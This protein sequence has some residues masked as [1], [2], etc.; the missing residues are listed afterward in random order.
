M[1]VFFIFLFFLYRLGSKIPNVKR[2]VD[3]PVGS[4]H[5]HDALFVLDHP[6]SFVLT[7]GAVASIVLVDQNVFGEESD[8]HQMHMVGFK[9]GVLEENFI[10]GIP[11]RVVEPDLD[12]FQAFGNASIAVPG[13]G[14]ADGCPDQSHSGCFQ[15]VEKLYTSQ[16]IREGGAYEPSLEKWVDVVG[17]QGFGSSGTAIQLLADHPGI[18]HHVGEIPFGSG[19]N[20]VEEVV[21]TTL[22]VEGFPDFGSDEVT[23]PVQSTNDPS[24]VGVSLNNVESLIYPRSG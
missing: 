9:P 24:L 6:I 14:G 17:H 23:D 18:L 5:G 1:A 2:E 12:V 13:F 20:D 19:P 10:G 8:G 4:L 15:V 22:G 21:G 16:S 7:G 3:G 11:Y